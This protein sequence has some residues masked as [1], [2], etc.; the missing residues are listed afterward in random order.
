[1]GKNQSKE[2]II[3]AQAGNSGST[4]NGGFTFS[5]YEILFFFHFV[6]LNNYWIVGYV[7]KM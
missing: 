3:I 5:S 1:M 6:G 7:P 2:E 4:T